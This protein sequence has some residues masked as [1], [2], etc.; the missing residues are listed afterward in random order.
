M[1]HIDWSSFKNKELQSKQSEK[2]LGW[3]EYLDAS[4]IRQKKNLKIHVPTPE[5]RCSLKN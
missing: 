1:F 4:M 2:L 3:N 5:P